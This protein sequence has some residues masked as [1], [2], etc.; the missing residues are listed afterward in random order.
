LT[1]ALCEDSMSVAMFQS[2]LFATCLLSAKA[3]SGGVNIR[4]LDENGAPSNSGLVEVSVPG[5]FG[6][7]CQMS[8]SSAD[9]V[10]RQL[11]FDFGSLSPSPC[12]SYGGSN[13]CGAAS[14]P[15]ALKSLNCKGNELTID[16]CSFSKPDESCLSH[17]RDALVFCGNTDSPP[18][19]EGSLRL[20]D[21]EGAPAISETG[22]G[23]TGRLEIFAAGSWAPVCKEGF[24]S[25]SASVACKQM[26]F[27][28]HSGSSS[29]GSKDLCGTVPPH[30]SEVA[31]SGSETSLFACSLSS[32]DDVF[33]APEES[34]V[35]SCAGKGDSIGRPFHLPAPRLVV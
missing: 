7:V 11:G 5:G 34:V 23:A 6:T 13:R 24:S 19:V 20:I 32:G 29:C 9:V 18:F 22:S 21:A 15:V 12:N 14:A 2:C 26:G 4:L 8:A 16:E 1:V 10:C 35:L 17:T 30:V 25:G 27:S 33:C 31:C 28:G 3:F